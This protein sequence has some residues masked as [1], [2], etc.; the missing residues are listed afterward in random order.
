LDE[1]DSMPLNIQAKLLRVLQDKEIRRVGGNATIPADV[2]V[3]AAT[4]TAGVKVP[5][6]A[7]LGV[8]S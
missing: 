2:R 5:N 7:G 8:P 3:L 4:V 6:F 1:I